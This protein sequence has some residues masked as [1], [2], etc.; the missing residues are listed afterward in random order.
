MEPLK[1]MDI[2]AKK[3]VVNTVMLFESEFYDPVNTAK[4]MWSQPVLLTYYN[5]FLDRIN[6][7]RC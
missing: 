3:K 6:P 1:E 7:L 4:V 2:H 5:F